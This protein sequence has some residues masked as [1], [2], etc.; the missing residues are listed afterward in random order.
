MGY[1]VANQR[2]AE[3][4]LPE[5]LAGDFAPIVKYCKY[6]EVFQ[7]IPFSLPETFKKMFESF[8]NAKFILTV[9][10]DADQWYRSLTRYHSNMF[11]KG[12]L[13]TSEQLKSHPYVYRGWAWQYIHGVYDTPEST[14]YDEETLKLAYTQF[15]DEVIHFFENYPD[16][17]L[18][19]NLKEENAF[20]RF[21]NFLG[22]KTDL[23]QFPWENQSGT[24]KV[25]I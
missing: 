22:A 17:F 8:P 10:D 9:R 13:P 12:S 18:L 2:K 11:G 7:D 15:N 23:T 6:G 3:K 20:E 24:M 21:V 1:V 4:L 25:K 5:Y 19:L 16:Q 14:P